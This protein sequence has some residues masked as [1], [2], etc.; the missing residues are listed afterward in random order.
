MKSNSNSKLWTD[1]FL[2]VSAVVIPFS[3]ILL[4]VFTPR[5]LVDENQKDTL[6]TAGLTA[7]VTGG[8]RGVSRRNNITQEVENQQVNL[9]PTSTNEYVQYNPPSLQPLSDSDDSHYLAPREHVAS[10]NYKIV[11]PDDE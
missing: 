4:S 3:L 10:A 6:L 7:L 1:D 8:F 11:S 5:S 2:A 9:A